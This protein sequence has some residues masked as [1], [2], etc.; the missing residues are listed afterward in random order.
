M[1]SYSRQ[2]KLVRGDRGGNHLT[3]QHVHIYTEYDQ[4]KPSTFGMADCYNPRS[5]AYNSNAN[6]PLYN[7]LGVDRKKMVSTKNHQ[8]STT[9][10][11]K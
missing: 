2:P 5:T 4:N 10:G 8:I 3:E 9:K 7:L 6:F 1:D 11:F